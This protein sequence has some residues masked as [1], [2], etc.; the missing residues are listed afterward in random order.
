MPHLKIKFS[1]IIDNDTLEEKTINRVG[2]AK[3]SI[4]HQ[5]IIYY[6][7]ELKKFSYSTYPKEGNFLYF[8]WAPVVPTL[9]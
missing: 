7:T 5:M 4:A 8:W 3:R 9:S 6:L 1:Q 2:C